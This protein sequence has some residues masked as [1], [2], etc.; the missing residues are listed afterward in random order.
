VAIKSKDRH[1][2]SNTGKSAR[3]GNL[4]LGHRRFPF[5]ALC[6]F[7]F[8]EWKNKKYYTVFSH[9]WDRPVPIFSDVRF[10]YLALVQDK[11][12]MCVLPANA[13]CTVTPAKVQDR[14]I[15][16]SGIGDFPFLHFLPVFDFITHFYQLFLVCVCLCWHKLWFFIIAFFLYV[17]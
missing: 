6:L 2:E 14:E 13:C 3:Q 9:F 8:L 10:S 7:V 12:I 17:F 11:K 1:I 4:T 15:L 16:P 5:L